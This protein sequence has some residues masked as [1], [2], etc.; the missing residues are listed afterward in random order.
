MAVR[1]LIPWNN[2][3]REVA[4]Q[5]SQESN[6]FLALPTAPGAPTRNAAMP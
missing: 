1:D 3:S 2:G 6:P 4:M 5:R